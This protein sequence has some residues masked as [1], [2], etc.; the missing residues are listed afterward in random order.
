[1]RLL[2]YM[3][4]T[5]PADFL[6][7]L[8]RQI[9]QRTGIETDTMFESCRS[10]PSLAELS[11][12][13]DPF[14][15]GKA[16]VCHLCA[17]TYVRARRR[18]VLELLGYTPIFYDKRSAGKPV[19]YS[20]VL[21]PSKSE[22]TQFEE[23]K[24]RS[25]AYNDKESLSGYFSMLYFLQQ[26]GEAADFFSRAICSGGHR[27]SLELLRRGESDCAA[28]DGNLLLFLTREN[29]VPETR[30]V[31]EIGPFPAPP[32]ALRTSLARS[33][34]S[35]LRSV[36]TELRADRE[37]MDLLRE[38]YLLSDFVPVT[39]DHYTPVEQILNELGMST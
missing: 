4:P 30:K 32:L 27:D 2:S 7:E 5:I 19:Y 6:R 28:I 21:V 15:L 10:G 14:S 22:V 34:K 9:Q 36:M 31:A 1:M 37:S 17:P 33:V 26:R 35:T 18:G 29:S 38:R 25:W 39:D 13:L 24:G 8:A 20:D 11:S 12:A 16:D 23:L 3:S